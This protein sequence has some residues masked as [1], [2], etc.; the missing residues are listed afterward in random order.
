MPL[1]TERSPLRRVSITGADDAVDPQGLLELA[2]R[3]PRVEWALLL[4]PEKEGQARNPTR[5]WRERFL[6]LHRS[7][8]T[9]GFTA[10]H[11][12]GR[13]VFEDILNGVGDGWSEW[14]RYDRIQVN[15]NA[16]RVL[17]DDD[18][19]LRIY[20]AL[21][22]AGLTMILQRHEHSTAVIDRFLNGLPSFE[23]VGVLFD[24]SKG[25]GA[26]P[27]QWA[28]ILH[29]QGVPVFCGYAGGLSPIT[30]PE[31]LPRI[32]AAAGTVPY[33]I[34]MES[35]VRSDNAFDLLKAEAV[36]AQVDHV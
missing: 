10:L 16:R 15:I 5:A 25:R 1:P 8:S 9:P 7:T 26:L 31:A 36:L 14:S 4:L 17:F 32:V 30:L 33:W 22:D 23:R 11:L 35:G 6:D 3:Y 29:A 20:H 18:Q 12:C 13:S 28:P 21:H 34:D 2:H 24:G 27:E 19:V